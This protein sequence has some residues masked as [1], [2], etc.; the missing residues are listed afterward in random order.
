MPDRDD[1]EKL[2][3][4][5]AFDYPSLLDENATPSPEEFTNPPGISRGKCDEPG[6]EASDP[7]CEFEVTAEVQDEVLEETK[8]GYGIEGFEGEE[9]GGG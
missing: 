1:K 8:P 5:G 2:D 4:S 3:R 7:E 6:A 9:V